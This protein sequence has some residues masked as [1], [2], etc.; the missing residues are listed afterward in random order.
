MITQEKYQN[1]RLFSGPRVQIVNQFDTYCVSI[2][3]VHR[4][5]DGYPNTAY[6]SG[7]IADNKNSAAT[8]VLD[9]FN[10]YF[11]TNTCFLSTFSYDLYDCL[12][13]EQPAEM[14]KLRNIQIYSSAPKMSRYQNFKR[15][16][17]SDLT[18]IDRK[19]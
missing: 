13:S 18:L 9:I 4:C 10:K 2:G 8:S 12:N 15:I 14:M 5:G 6:D 11:V 7:N 16:F 1:F 17:V 19:L 3:K